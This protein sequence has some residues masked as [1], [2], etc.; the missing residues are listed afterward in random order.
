NAMRY[1]LAVVAYVESLAAPPP[2][3]LDKR[4]RDWFDATERH[5][6]QLHE[7]DREQYLAMKRNETR[8]MP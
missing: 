2:Q 5:A 3:R 7:L 8:G 6:L 4:L 1:Y